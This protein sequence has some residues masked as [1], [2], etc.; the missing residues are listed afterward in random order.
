[1]DPYG[2]AMTIL[3]IVAEQLTLPPTRVLDVGCGAGSWLAAAWDLWKVDC[4]GLDQGDLPEELQQKWSPRWMEYRKVNL[5]VKTLKPQGT[6]DLAIC[7]EVAE[8]LAEPYGEGLVKFLCKSAPAVLFSAAPPGQGPYPP[9]GSLID[10]WSA[11]H[12]NEQPYSYWG[13]LFEAQGF[14][15]RDVIRPRV[16]PP[17]W[18]DVWY[19][20]NTFL[21]FTRHAAG[22]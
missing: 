5:A 12:I 13:D 2:S 21:Y 4:V 19:R 1:M 14:E 8:H 11:W 20:A 15:Q 10:K 18:V 16:Q 6:F 22:D 3:P 9:D 7:L 17:A